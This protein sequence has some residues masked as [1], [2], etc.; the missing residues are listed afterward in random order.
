M[1]SIVIP[2][3]NEGSAVV[4]TVNSIIQG[5]NAEEIDF[6]IILVDDGSIDNTSREISQHLSQYIGSSLSILEHQHNL[7]YGAAIKTGINNA[8]GESIGILDADETYEVSDFIRLFKHFQKSGFDMV[9]GQRQGSHFQGNFSKRILRRLLKKLV[10]FMTG[11]KIPDI[12]SGSRIFRRDLAL[13]NFNLLSD[14]FSF[15]TSITLVFM[16]RNA[17]VDYLPISYNARNG[18]SKVKLI[19]DS[20][21]TLGFVLTISLYFNPL[22]IFA[23][24]TLLFLFGSLCNLVTFVFTGK[25]IF[26]LVASIFVATTAIIF[27]LGLLAHLLGEKVSTINQSRFMYF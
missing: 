25:S 9:V 18:K 19:S 13:A 3:Y 1:L 4:G 23:P 2:V 8:Q 20:I 21:R 17:F 5:L 6:E 11:R 22:R 7:G 16:M 27:A 26:L 10:E 24:I 15:T 14:K 12:N